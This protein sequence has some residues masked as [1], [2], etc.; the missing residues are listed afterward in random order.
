MP[1]DIGP[2]I[3]FHRAPFIRV[4]VV[5]LAAVLAAGCAT[6]GARQR[7]QGPGATGV[8]IE[9]AAGVY[10]VHGAAGE[11]DPS[12]AG[13]IGN[14][15]F[16]VG[17]SGVIAIDTGTSY[18]HGVALLEAIAAVTDKPIRLVLITHARQ[19]FLFG[20]AAYRERGIP[21]HMHRQAARLMAAR[22]ENCLK[23][24]KRVLGDEAMRGTVMFKPDHEFDQPYQL[25]LIG[26]PLRVLYYGHTSGP[27]D[28]GVLDLQSGVLFAGG[29]LDQQRIPDIQD[30]D[31]ERW[32]QALRALRELPL[33]VVVPGHGPAAPA[34]VI[35]AVGH[36]LT[37]LET[38]V[39]E[40][41]HAGAALSDVPD[42]AVL[43]EFKDW[44]QYDTIHRRNAAIVFLRLEREQVFK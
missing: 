13:R 5:L 23:T 31:L 7:T 38:R 39:L 10:M 17:E 27:G 40:L 14:A 11:I 20:A 28:I 41:M 19:E 33:E 18:R 1:A 26:R 25:D 16:V 22:C 29:L 43:P 44:D 37:Q 4:L 42:A 24:L 6:P 12:N 32:Q 8:A 34:S 9:V 35:D 15:G 3:L 30:S 2:V 36:Y 21:V